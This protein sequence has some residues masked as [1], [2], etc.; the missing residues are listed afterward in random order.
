LDIE[1]PAYSLTPEIPKYFPGNIP[2]P[3]IEKLLRDVPDKF[4]NLFTQAQCLIEDHIKFIKDKNWRENSRN[5]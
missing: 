2:E 3:I 4:R 1:A 5:G